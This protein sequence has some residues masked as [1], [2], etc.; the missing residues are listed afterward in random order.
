MN[1]LGKNIDSDG[2]RALAKTCNK[3][4]RLDIDE[5]LID[6]E[7]LIELAKKCPEMKHLCLYTCQDIQDSGI[8]IFW[9]QITDFSRN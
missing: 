5:V 2:I 8:F 7:T 1:F 4:V 3:L 6:N 9:L